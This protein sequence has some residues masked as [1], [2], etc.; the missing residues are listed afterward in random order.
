VEA[1][2]DWL[3]GSVTLFVLMRAM[4]LGLDGE[5]VI[6]R[7]FADVKAPRDAA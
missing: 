4:F 6:H 2:E 7:E 3:K 1:F 5:V